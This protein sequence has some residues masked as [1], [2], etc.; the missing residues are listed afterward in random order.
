MLTLSTIA[1]VLIDDGGSDQITWI[2]LWL[3]KASWTGMDSNDV[4]GQWPSKTL[5]TRITSRP[6]FLGSQSITRG[7]VTAMPVSSYC[8]ANRHTVI[9]Q[10]SRHVSLVILTNNGWFYRL[11]RYIWTTIR[12]L[13]VSG[14][15]WYFPSPGDIEWH[16][17]IKRFNTEIG[18]SIPFVGKSVAYSLIVRYQRNRRPKPRLYGRHRHHHRH[19]WSI[20]MRPNQLSTEITTVQLSSVDAHYVIHTSGTI[21]RNRSE[22]GIEQSSSRTVS[23]PSRAG[24]TPI[25]EF[26]CWI[27]SQ[28]THSLMNSC[29]HC[30]LV[31]WLL[32]SGWSL[33]PKVLCSADRYCKRRL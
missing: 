8:K 20:Q 5:A 31:F 28:N 19:H 22:D 23:G 12:N 15:D 24:F 30:R 21:L 7:I 4:M 16:S 17:L 33:I 6:M 2:V 25:K 11:Q 14:I 13:W 29:C 10:Y 26:Q 9:V 1:S 32:L 3:A 27:W 18:G